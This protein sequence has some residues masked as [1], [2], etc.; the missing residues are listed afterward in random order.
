M[1]AALPG[2]SGFV[3]GPVLGISVHGALEEPTVVE[4]LI[5]RAPERS[6][7]AVFDDLADLVEAR[8]NIA[9]LARSAGVERGSE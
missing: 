9:R 2:G 1:A 7:E 3:A 6:L 4:A 8:L 5:G